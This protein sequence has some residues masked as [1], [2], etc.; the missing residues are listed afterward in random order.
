MLEEILKKLSKDSFSIIN[1]DIT[2]VGK[3]PKIISYRE[4]IIENLSKILAI[5]S[6]KISCKATTT[7]GLGFEGNLEGVSCHCISLIE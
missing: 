1:I 6:N 5:D 3:I 2:Y 7:D 4:A